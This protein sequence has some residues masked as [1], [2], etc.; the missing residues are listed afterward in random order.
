[1]K[2]DRKKLLRGL[3]IAIAVIAVVGIGLRIADNARIDTGGEDSDT[4]QE[5][6]FEGKTYV[7]KNNVKSYLFIGDDAADPEDNENEGLCDTLV[8]LAVDRADESYAMLPIDR[9]TVASVQTYNKEGKK[10]GDPV[11][12][13]IAF[14]H[15]AAYSDKISCRN[16]VDSVKKLLGIK[17]ID[18][19]YSLNMNGIGLVNNMAGG[20]TV[21]VND[22]FPAGSGLTK[23]ETIKLSDEQA[24]EYLRG[25]K[26][27][28]DGS[29]ENRMAR[30]EDYFYEF[31]KA[32]KK[33]Q[34]KNPDI[35]GTI[36]EKLGSYAYTDMTGQDINRISNAIV[37]Y[38]SKGMLHIDGELT[39]DE[40]GWAA[41]RADKNSIKH[42]VVTLFY[43]EK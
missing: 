13:Q 10:V 15:S 23:G 34:G 24:V 36:E 2:T 12:I 4:G 18:G 8:L 6:Q 16:T 3:I 20:V 31:L 26:E 25:R 11:D 5:I 21:T 38:E 37:N 43:E 32:F 30:Q 27:V 35:A 9:N 1:M 40:F 14:A 7:P 29:N 19:F 17:H 39:E 28:S 22:D 33:K 41:F 42:A